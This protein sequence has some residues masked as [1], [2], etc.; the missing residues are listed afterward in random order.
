M[1]AEWDAYDLVAPGG[2]TVEVKSAAYLQSWA[3]NALSSICFDVAPSRAWSA[4]TTTLE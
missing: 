2:T 4:A 1:R 3:Q